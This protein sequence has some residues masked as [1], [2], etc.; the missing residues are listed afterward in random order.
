[1]K[2]LMTKFNML[3]DVF[4]FLMGVGIGFDVIVGEEDF[5]VICVVLNLYYVY[6][7]YDND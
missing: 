7:E 2:F 3:E 4:C 6:L 5:D 1:M